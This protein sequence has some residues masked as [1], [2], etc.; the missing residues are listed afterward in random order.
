MSVELDAATLEALMDL[1]SALPDE[2]PPVEAFEEEEQP[3]RKKSRKEKKSKHDKKRKHEK[4]HSSSKYIDEAADEG[5]DGDEGEDEGEIEVVEED[6]IKNHKPMRHLFRPGDDEVD[7]VALAREIEE[8]NRLSLK[9]SRPRRNP[10]TNIVETSHHE[11][12]ALVPKKIS[13]ALRFSSSFLPQKS[14]PKVFAVKCRPGMSR[15]LVARVVNKCYHYSIGKNF[16]NKKV[17]LGIISCFAL[18]HIKE[19]IYIEAHRQLFVENAL[20]GLVGLFRYNIQP[21]DP[22]ELVQLLSFRP[23]TKNEVRVGQFVRLR[24]HPY[25]ND[26]AQVLA[27][28]EDGKKAQVQLIPRE[29]FAGKSYT[30]ST[31]R[32]PQKFFMPHQAVGVHTTSEGHYRWGDL[33][34]DHEGY[35]IRLVGTRN[36][37]AGDNM[38]K[39]SV[40]ELAAFFKGNKDQIAMAASCVNSSSGSLP[41]LCVGE[42]VRVIAGQ[43]ANA[44]G[45]I[46]DLTQMSNS[47]KISCKVPGRSEPIQIRTELS[48]CTK[49]F[50]VGDHITVQT[51]PL[52]G[53][54]GTVVKATQHVVVVKSD[55][56][57]EEFQ[58]TL[59]DARLSKLVP[60]VGHN[61][62]SW[63]LFD[64]VMLVDGVTIGC[65]V[66]FELASISILTDKNTVKSITPPQIKSA[67]RTA[68]RVVSDRIGNA[69]SRGSEVVVK[70]VGNDAPGA[71]LDQICVVEQIFNDTLFVRC[72]RV[73]ANSGVVAVIAN[74]TML[75]GGKTTTRHVAPPKQ[76][77]L[78]ERKGHYASKVEGGPTDATAT[79]KSEEWT[80]QS[81][82][83]E[84][85]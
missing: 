84:L 77:P 48:N 1:P 28:L 23:S 32:Q 54:R 50:L 17:D 44:I 21:V 74:M 62:G 4:K 82:L 26:L 68:G 36:L 72:G 73:S 42:V 46:V 3:E 41:D 51:G 2:A 65:I 43:L 60:S 78:P 79:K 76:L 15:L 69:V 34:F 40:E 35:L 8:R 5:S 56:L 10:T 67:V 83:Y 59:N 33:V 64:L 31:V 25:K 13:L 49:H 18:D 55:L 38:V 81:V 37:F 14:D 30:K 47:V 58:V 61:F 20:N 29:D 39:P 45:T 12:V 85:E 27:V 24:Q 71:V 9:N 75:V 63:R 53:S 11:E 6:Y 57:T 22:S 7:E 16:E 80:A 52:K 19:Y 70:S 66:K